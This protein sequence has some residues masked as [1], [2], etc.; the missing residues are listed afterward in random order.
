MAV[1]GKISVNTENIFPIIKK[2]LYSDHDIF[3][4]ELVANAED[5]SQK[6]Q[7]LASMGE[8]NGELGDLNVKISIDK[9]AGTLTISDRGLGM[10]AEEV[11]KYIN[12]V[13]FSGATEFVEKFKD[14]DT[15]NII[16]KFGLG[17]YSAFMVS[18]KVE[19][20]TKSY[21]EGSQAVKWSCDGS[22]E[23]E[24][25]DAERAERGSD[26]ILYV[27]ED[28]K[29][30]LEDH[31]IS[32]ILNKYCKFMP[33]PVIFGTETETIKEG[34]GDDAKE[35]KIEKEKVINNTAPLW[36]KD[37][38]ELSDED[39]RNFYKELYPYGEEPLFWIHLNVDYPFNLTGILY[40]PKIK[41][42]I[43]QHQNKVQ[44]YSRQVFITDEVKDILPE[45]LG[46]MHGVIDSPDIPLNVSRSYLQSDANVKKISNYITRKVAD[47]LNSLFNSDREGFEAK[48]ESIGLFVKYGMMSDEK[49][50]D[51]AKKFCLYKNMDDKLFTF[52][53]YKAKIEAEQVDKDGNHVFLY[54]TNPGQQH[55]YIESA[56]RKGYDVLKF[57]SMIDNH[58]VS[59]VEQKLEKVQLK[60]VDADTV[61]KLVEKEISMESLLSEDDQ[62]KVVEIFK[63]ALG[64][65]NMDLQVQALPA[66]EM[67][68]SIVL[69]EFMRRMKEMAEM[70]GGGGMFGM[71][72]MPGSKNIVINANNPM[73]E[74]IL[75]S[76]DE[77]A[78]NTLARHA[79]DLAQLSQGLL[80][81]AELSAF[82]ARDLEIM[83]K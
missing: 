18:D 24:I 30:F 40:F 62:N 47:K 45:F 38:K 14:E 17:F 28:S 12:Q 32:E 13:A 34:E 3:L 10:T 22:I 15:S 52:D 66:E 44:L 51:K 70:Q 6:L 75:K 33:I 81:G 39:Y 7:K 43:T 21:K 4:R 56:K 5:A 69:P 57:D 83:N 80:T 36:T 54:T 74:R 31:R 26:I 77:T 25:T 60:R 58:F 41:N 50:F 68:V 64:N 61:E 67:P 48:W 59:N 37:P 71:G 8:F 82:I 27:N 55:T 1:K 2:F 20:V 42:D 23:F 19:I 49:F 9:E 35:E 46:L 73:V 29:E 76:E 63:K 65:D 79:Y 16:G 72:D 11:E 53:E 78:Q